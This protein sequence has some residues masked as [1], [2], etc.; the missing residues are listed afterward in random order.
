MILLPFLLVL[1][2][3]VVLAR[4]GQGGSRM[5]TTNEPSGAAA[6]PIGDRTPDRFWRLG[7]LY[8][9]RD[10]PAVLVEKRFGLGYTLNFARPTTWIILLLVLLGA[11]V[12]LIVV[13]LPG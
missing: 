8:F 10:D 2:V 3:V 12:P 9:N 1:V 6:A 13:K 4:L 11:L 7:I 5:Q